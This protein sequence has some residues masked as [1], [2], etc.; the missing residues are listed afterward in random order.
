MVRAMTNRPC[1]ATALSLVLLAG[2]PRLVAAA[3]PAQL[4]PADREVV[5]RFTS[6]FV[7][8]RNTWQRNKWLGIATLQNP[9]DAWVTQEIITETKPDFIVETGTFAG[10]SALLWATVLDQVNPKGRVLTIDVTDVSQGAR[11]LPLWSRHCE[12]LHGSSVAP[13]IVEQ[14]KR[15]V[16]KRSAM[17]ILDSLHTKEHVLNE[18]RAYAPLVHPGGYVIV[19]D[20]VFNGHPVKGGWGE[21][22]YEAIDAFLAENDA[23]VA[24]RDREHLLMTF[25]PHGFLR[26]VK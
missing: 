11:K 1:A 5:D 18:L 14:V 24:D 25:N 22:P 19:Q 21:G 20:A 6:M 17:V 15:K 26:R 9:L 7:E 4:S 8:S 3:E 23:F 10:G 12:F 16:G 13:E 2:V